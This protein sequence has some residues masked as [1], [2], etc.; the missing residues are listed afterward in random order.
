MA[1]DIP[2]LPSLPAARVTARDMVDRYRNTNVSDHRAVA[3]AFGALLV[4]LGRLLDALDREEG[5]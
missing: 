4:I 5:P 1:R 3:E 2:S